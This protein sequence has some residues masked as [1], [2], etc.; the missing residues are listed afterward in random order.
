[1]NRAHVFITPGFIF[2]AN[3][4]RYLRI[5]LCATEK[6]ITEAKDRL[7]KMNG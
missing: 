7:I 4:E 6:R 5:S 2:G 1:L 3:G